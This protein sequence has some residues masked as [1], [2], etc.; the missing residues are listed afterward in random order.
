MCWIVVS[1]PFV[2]DALAALWL[3]PWLRRHVV[4]WLL[5][6][7][8]AIVDA[9]LTT[10]DDAIAVAKDLVDSNVG[11]NVHLHWYTGSSSRAG[12]VWCAIVCL[13]SAT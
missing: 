4:A 3:L 6:S 2:T 13:S 9:A 8:G 10:Q 12:R 7:S 1:R 11:H 5:A